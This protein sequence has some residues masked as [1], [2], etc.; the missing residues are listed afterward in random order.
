MESNNF[1]TG[2]AD[3]KNRVSETFENFEKNKKKALITGITGQDGYYLA[4]FLLN[5]G[6]EVYGMYRR[7]SL[8]VEARIFELRDKIKLVEGDLIDPTSIIRILK[9]IKPTEHINGDG[10][11]LTVTLYALPLLILFVKLKLPFITVRLSVPLFCR[12]TE[13]VNPLTVPLTL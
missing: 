10:W 5:K 13:P 11:V 8:E 2:I 3:L 9:E 12:T 1:S 4:K 7:S 6:Y